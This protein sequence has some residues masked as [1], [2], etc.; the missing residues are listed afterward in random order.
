MGLLILFADLEAVF[1]CLCA[2]SAVGTLA[3]MW[4]SHSRPAGFG[5]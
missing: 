4:A 2:L 1:W 3:L 5:S